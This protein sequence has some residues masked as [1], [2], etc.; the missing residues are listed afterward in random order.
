MNVVASDSWIWFKDPNTQSQ[1]LLSV[2][3][4][5]EFMKCVCEREKTDSLVT[6]FPLG[7]ST[8]RMA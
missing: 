3:E 2:Q 6:A 8:S 5:K 7:S 1:N 4:K